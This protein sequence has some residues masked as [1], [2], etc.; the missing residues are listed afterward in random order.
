M[1]KDD[2]ETELA[3]NLLVSQFSLGE[4]NSPADAEEVLAAWQE[5]RRRIQELAA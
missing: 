4:F 5:H 3:T 1:P 2:S